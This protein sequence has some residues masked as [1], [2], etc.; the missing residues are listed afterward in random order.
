MGPPSLHMRSFRDWHERLSASAPRPRVA[1]PSTAR[2]KSASSP[3]L[4]KLFLES[5]AV[6]AG[7]RGTVMFRSH[8]AHLRRGRIKA[9]PLRAIAFRAAQSWPYSLSCA[10]VS[11]CRIGTSRDISRTMEL[12]RNHH[13][14]PVFFLSRWTGKDGRFC[15]MKLIRGKLVAKRPYPDGTG[16]VKDLYRT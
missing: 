12:P 13:F 2:R 9:R 16:Y 11:P 6:A 8:S 1:F 7:Q 3:G 15:E 4:R 5:F 10:V 14:K